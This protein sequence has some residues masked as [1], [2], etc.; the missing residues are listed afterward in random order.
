MGHASAAAQVKW[1]MSG[2][3]TAR[4]P[5]FGT[6]GTTSRVRYV[7]RMIVMLWGE[8]YGLTGGSGIAPTVQA[9]T[10][11]F[12]TTPFLGGLGGQLTEGPLQLRGLVQQ[13]P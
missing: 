8:R 10:S 2:V 4:H 11:A 6:F 7:E 9:A 12:D 13:Q 3:H 1:H 5:Q